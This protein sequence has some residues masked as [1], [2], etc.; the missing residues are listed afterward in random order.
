MLI[1]QSGETHIIEGKLG[2]TQHVGQLLRYVRSVRRTRGRRPALTVV[3]D[4][5][6]FSQSRQRAFQPINRQVKS[7]RFVTWSQVAEGGGTCSCQCNPFGSDAKST[8]IRASG[9][10]QPLINSRFIERVT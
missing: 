1:R 8:S 2:P 4:G 9:P 7:L 3:D 10:P 5:S 6:E